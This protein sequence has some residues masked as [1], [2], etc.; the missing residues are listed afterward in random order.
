LNIYYIAE[1]RTPQCERNIVKIVMVDLTKKGFLRE[2][3]SIEGVKMK[4]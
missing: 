2:V 4:D 1:E 3:I